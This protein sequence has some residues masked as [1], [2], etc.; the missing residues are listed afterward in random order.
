MEKKLEQIKKSYGIHYDT[1]RSTFVAFLILLFSLIGSFCPYSHIFFG[2][3]FLMISIITVTSSLSYHSFESSILPQ[4][5]DK[6]NIHQ[7]WYTR[8]AMWIVFIGI[9]IVSMIYGYNILRF[10]GFT[11]FAFIICYENYNRGWFFKERYSVWTR[12]D[13]KIIERFQSV[14]EDSNDLQEYLK[15]AKLYYEECLEKRNIWESYPE[16][17]RTMKHFYIERH[18]YLSP[19]DFVYLQKL[20]R[21]IKNFDLEKFKYPL[22]INENNFCFEGDI[23]MIDSIECLKNLPIKYLG[24]IYEPHF[25]LFG[26]GETL[27][28]PKELLKDFEHANVDQVKQFFCSKEAEAI[29]IFRLIHIQLMKEYGNHVGKIFD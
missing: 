9:E 15:K 12:C 2:I 21:N 29:H 24:G 28:I 19:Q 20:D 3:S 18:D 6:I 26:T 27:T 5:D 8:L 4:N 17:I 7:Y 1:T 16:E 11:L 22:F 23:I 10:I 25:E 14:F 13:T